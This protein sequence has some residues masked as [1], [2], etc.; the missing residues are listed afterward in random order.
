MQSREPN[1]RRSREATL[2]LEADGDPSQNL[3]PVA[4]ARCPMMGTNY[5]GILTVV[6][7]RGG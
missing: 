7:T 6:A 1:L 4:A 2:S 5:P 3:T